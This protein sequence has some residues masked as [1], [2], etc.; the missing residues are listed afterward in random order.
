M[1][2]IIKGGFPFEASYRALERLKWKPSSDKIFIKPN[3]G[4]TSK[5]VNT[6][7]EIVR[8]IIDYCKDKLRIDD[9]IIGEGSVETEYESTA[10]NFRYQGW[11]KL[12]KEEN[13]ELVDL[14]KVER[15]T[16]SWHYGEIKI[17]GVLTERSYINVA[18][19][20]THMQTTVSLCT[21]NQKGL[22]DSSTRKL[23]H[24]LGLHEPIKRL[25]EFVKPEL[26]VVDGIV[27][28]EGNG[29]GDSGTPRKDGLVVAGDN[30]LQVDRTC[31]RIMGINP[32][33]VSHLQ[34]APDNP[35]TIP[36]IRPFKLPDKEFKMFNV[37][38][39]PEN[40]CSACLSSVGKTNKLARETGQGLG[41]FFKHGILGRLDIIVGSPKEIPEDHGFCLFY[42]NCTKELS[43]R[44]PEYPFIEGCPPVSKQVL[45][46]LVNHVEKR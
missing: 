41:F 12:A 4:A 13:V 29:P 21:K 31:C 28:V 38:M 32:D 8:G 20:K 23:F 26:C 22:L 5:F 35:V 17:P 1:I 46:K 6:D 3:I 19:M 39:R 30:M 37:Y 45:E 14:N 11:D 24:K 10:Y 40:A 15:V 33:T 42:G 36:K 2:I 43:T 7:P 16:V 27:G 44:Y 9:I 25:S 34:S 18:K